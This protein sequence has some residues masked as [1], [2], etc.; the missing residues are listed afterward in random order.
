MI[1]RLIV[2]EVEFVAEVKPNTVELAREFVSISA[3]E[4]AQVISS[5]AKRFAR[6]GSHHELVCSQADF[7][8]SIANSEALTDQAKRSIIDLAD[9]IRGLDAT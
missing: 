3:A 6:V 5:I 2:K 8:S 7:L 9:M 1:R 4:Q